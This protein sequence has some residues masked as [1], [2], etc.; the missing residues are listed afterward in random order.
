MRYVPIQSIKEGS[1]L[2][3]SVYGHNGH[4][5]LKEGVVLDSY[6]IQKLNNVGINGVY[7]EDE[8]SKGI[9]VKSVISEELRHKAVLSVQKTFIYAQK[10]SSSDLE[11]K[12][13]NETINN[14]TKEIVDEI[15]DSE[16]LMI[17]M[18]DL[19][20][21]D[22]YTFYHSLNVAIIS[23]VLGCSL[24]LKKE[25][26]Y[27]LGLSA[28]MHDIG[29]IF[30]PKDVLNKPQKLDDK[31]WI[32]MKKHPTRG[33]KYLKDKFK[34][35]AES[36]KG[37]L[38]HHER[39]NGTGYPNGFEYKDI[40]LYSRIIAVA[41]VYD[42]L[43]SDRPYRKGLLPSEAI[44]FILSGNDVLFDPEIVN[45]FIRKVT[46]YPSGTIVKLSNNSVAIVVENF[47]GHGN[48]PLVRVFI[49]SSNS[50]EPYLVDLRKKE[51]LS[52]TIIGVKKDQELA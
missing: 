21:F 43:I 12:E 27:S 45:C 31:E 2:K 24:S 50:V 13:T 48:R 11:N 5:L 18:I 41:D 17:N 37:I 49:E 22:D 52:L 34:L 7:I 42:A 19:K 29:K 3:K 16:N 44:E 10:S 1:I 38:S 47:E 15:L 4:I 40:N 14:I 23:I 46:P 6:Y 36:Y 8:L 26:L 51:N 9:E 32:L 28:I 33:F 35:P 20:V 39:W 30:V 25:E